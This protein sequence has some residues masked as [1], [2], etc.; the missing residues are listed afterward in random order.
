M[1]AILLFLK[2]F[3]MGIA[4]IIP[5]VSGGTLAIILGIY[6]KLIDILSAFWKN[7][8]E[9][10][11]FLLPLF[12][13]LGV[14]ILLGSYAIDW[15]LKNFP[16]ATTMFFIGLV[17]GGIP[18]IYL[19]VH[20]KY[21]FVNISIFIIVAAIVILISLLSFNKTV[22]L[23]NIDF[24]L[25]IKLFFVGMIAAGTMIIP[26][27]SG[28]L[29]LMNLGYYDGIISAIK[30]LTDL[31]NFGHNVC[32]LLPF[33][34]GVLFGLVLIARLIKWLINKFPVQSYFGI[35]AFVIAS[36][37]CIIIKMD[38]SNFNVGELLLGFVLLS[39]GAFITFI[40]ARY[41]YNRSIN[42]ESNKESTEDNI[43]IE[44]QKKDVE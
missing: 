27:I 9:S 11:K 19:K 30:G 39:I 37:V 42:S 40:L 41:D 26:G 33:G 7:I 43:E 38:R 10:I 1:K 4:N 29:V 2:G 12:L 6:E 17:L 23:S 14:A 20:K 22:S 28:S 25:I 35:L 44:E 16:I 3:I 13:G 24:L 15:G 34:I 5:G 36:I 32:I 8:K 31:S 21:S 18:Y